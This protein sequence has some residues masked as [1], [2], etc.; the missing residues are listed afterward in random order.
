[1][2]GLGKHN[3]SNIHIWWIERSNRYCLLHIFVNPHL[4]IANEDWKVVLWRQSW[5][6]SWGTLHICASL[7][8]ASPRALVLSRLQM[9]KGHCRPAPL[10]LLQMCNNTFPQTV[11]MCQKNQKVEK[12]KKSLHLV[13]GWFMLTQINITGWNQIIKRLDSGSPSL[14][15]S[16]CPLQPEQLT[17]VSVD[18]V[19]IENETDLSGRRCARFYDRKKPLKSRILWHPLR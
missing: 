12:K 8:Y 10:F 17:A 3:D 6:T 7:I 2:V 18:I 19:C 4:Y 15:G 9:C 1:M 11:W 13:N 5:Y 16:G 14:A